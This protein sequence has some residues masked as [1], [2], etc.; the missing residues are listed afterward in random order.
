MTLRTTL[1]TATAVAALVPAAALAKGGDKLVFAGTCSGASTS[2][3]KLKTDDGRIELE[4]EVDQNVRRVP[5]HVT[6]TQNGAPLVST[7]ART[8]GRSGSFTVKRRPRDLS[9]VDTFAATATSPS[10]ETCSA[11]GSL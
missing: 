4:L 11:T 1:L 8:G 10:S 6:I 2:E 5:W 3:L 7:T 9:G